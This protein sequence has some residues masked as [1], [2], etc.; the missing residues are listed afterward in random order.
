MKVVFSDLPT[1][2]SWLPESTEYWTLDPRASVN[3][4]HFGKTY[5]EQLSFMPFI[6][7][8]QTLPHLHG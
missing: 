4:E 7:N 8:E 1:S 2:V 6:R 3:R 5:R